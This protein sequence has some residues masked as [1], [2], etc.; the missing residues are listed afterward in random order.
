MKKQRD[1]NKE[2]YLDDDKDLVERLN[3]VKPMLNV[4]RR[5]QQEV[6]FIQIEAILRSRKSMDDFD[7]S[8][9]R[10]SIILGVFAIIQI[11]I[12]FLQ[13]T[14]SVLEFENKWIGYIFLV[15]LTAMVVFIIKEVDL[16]LKDK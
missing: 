8:T 13:F 16:L 11:V 14:L 15:A 10:F 12:A 6:N 2:Q 7:R 1:D 4:D 5:E 3:S 9:T